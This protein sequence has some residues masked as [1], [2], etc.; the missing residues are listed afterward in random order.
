MDD[1]TADYSPV[2]RKARIEIIPLIDVV[3]FLLATFVLFT[4]SLAKI[5]A[6]DVPLPVTGPPV[7]GPDTT[8][9]LQ[10]SHD[11]VFYW[12]EGRDGPPEIVARE[13]IAPRLASYARRVAKPRVFVRGDGHATFGAAVMLFDEVRR[14]GIKHASVETVVSREGS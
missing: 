11:G 14:A 13:A 6:L 5:R 7:A 8:I 2:T 10:A 12:K 4:I 1:F 9:Y 3:F